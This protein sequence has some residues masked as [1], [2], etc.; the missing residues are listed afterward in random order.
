MFKHKN[1][2]EIKENKDEYNTN[3]INKRKSV[4]VF[5]KNLKN[6]LFF[7]LLNQSQ[8]SSN[9]SRKSV[10]FSNEIKND[11][12]NNEHNL[13]FYRSEN[14][15]ENINILNQK[16]RKEKENVI[17]NESI[18][19]INIKNI[20]D[21][22]NKN[23]K[24]YEKSKSVTNLSSLEMSSI[25]SKIKI[26]KKLKTTLKNLH[27]SFIESKKNNFIR[28]NN[29]HYAT[30]MEYKSR[31]NFNKNMIEQKNKNKEYLKLDLLII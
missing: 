21:K 19:N 24:I 30:I 1:I 2:C 9:Q 5:E 13:T 20:C 25:F 18:K 23:I 14:S 27:Q 8:N 16:F 4:N 26:K 10:I 17:S 3:F 22:S 15:G 11:L 29:L 6:N 31:S 7:K 28:A 12:T